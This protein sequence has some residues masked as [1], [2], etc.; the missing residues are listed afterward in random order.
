LFEDK[1]PVRKRILIKGRVTEF[2][3]LALPT[4]PLQVILN[5]FNPVLCNVESEEW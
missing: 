4:I 3:I 2:G 5:D 1:K